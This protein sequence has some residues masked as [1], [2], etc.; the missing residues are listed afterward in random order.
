M[1]KQEVDVEAAVRVAMTTGIMLGLFEMAG[2]RGLSLKQVTA[3][4]NRIM[5]EPGAQCLLADL[6]AL[7]AEVRS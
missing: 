1:K 3:R 4:V 7:K 6:A 5:L 2:E